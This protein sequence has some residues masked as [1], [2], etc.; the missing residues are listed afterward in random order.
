RTDWW[1]LYR[2]LPGS[3]IATVVGIDAEIG[4]PAW[5]FGSARY[6]MLA[7]ESVVFARTS[8]GYDGLARRAPDGTITEL[9]TP[10]SRIASVRAAL[11]G[12]VLVVA[13]SPTQEPGVHRVDL[14]GQVVETLRAPRELGSAPLDPLFV[15]VPEHITFPTDEGAVAHAL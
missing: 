2:Y 11:D 9:N 5:V 6:A 4:V 13:G 10:F 12:T 7:D 1:N 15:S 14:G 8:R 3:D